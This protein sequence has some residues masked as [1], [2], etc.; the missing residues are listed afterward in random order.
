MQL[1]QLLSVFRIFGSETKTTFH[2][3]GS[4]VTFENK[5]ADPLTLTTLVI[6]VVLI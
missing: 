1:R 5:D 4:L 2:S 3:V 6:P